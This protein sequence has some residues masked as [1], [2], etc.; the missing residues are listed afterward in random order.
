MS[1]YDSYYRGAVVAWLLRIGLYGG[2]M[3]ISAI[4]LSGCSVPKPLN[5]LPSMSADADISRREGHQ[6]RNDEPHSGG[7]HEKSDSSLR[8]PLT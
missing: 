2:I 7:C 6:T 4:V 8:K 5:I 3:A 1:T